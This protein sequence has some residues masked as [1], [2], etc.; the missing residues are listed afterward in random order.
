MYV[1]TEKGEKH[2]REHGFT[3]RIAGHPAMIGY[4]PAEDHPGL[5]KDWE[6]LGFIEWRK[7]DQA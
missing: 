6:R 3:D 5:A 7:E 2:A 1:Y 4:D